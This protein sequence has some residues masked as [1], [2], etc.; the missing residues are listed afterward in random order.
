ML[1]NASKIKQIRRSKRIAI[2][3]LAKLA[4][5]SRAQLYN[6]EKRGV[7]REDTAYKLADALGVSIEALLPDPPIEAVHETPSPIYG[8]SEQSLHNL[9]LEQARRAG[10]GKVEIKALADTLGQV[11]DLLTMENPGER[12]R[13]AT[14]IQGMIDLCHKQLSPREE[15]ATSISSRRKE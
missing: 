2:P 9:A 8:G 7:T 14:L 6:I 11:M 10:L 12:K 13:Y 4:S 5:V 15:G 3:E 1:I